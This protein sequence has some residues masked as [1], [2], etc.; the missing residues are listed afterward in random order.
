VSRDAAHLVPRLAVIAARSS[1]AY[2]PMGRSR[3]CTP[4]G[5]SPVPRRPGRGRPAGAAPQG[6][7]KPAARTWVVPR[8]HPGRD[9]R[10]Y[11]PVVAAVEEVAPGVEVVGPG[12]CALAAR[13]PSRY[14]R[15]EERA[16][17]RIVEHIARSARWRR[18]PA[19]P[20]GLR[21]PSRRPAGRLIPPGR[22]AAF[23]R[24]L[25]ISTV[26]DRPGRPAAQLGIGTP[27]LRR[28]A[29][30]GRVGTLRPGRRPAQRMPRA[31]RAATR[32]TAAAAGPG[33][34]ADLDEPSN[35][36][37]RRVRRP[38]VGRPAARAAGRVRAGLHP[39]GHRGGH[40]ARRGA[41]PDLAARRAAEC[42][43]HR[44]RCAGSWTAGCSGTNRG[45]A[46]PTGGILRL[47][48]VPEGVV[49]HAG[50]QLRL[51]GDAGHDASGRTGRSPGYRACSAP[52]R[53]SRRYPVVGTTRRTRYA[54]C[55]GATSAAR[56]ARYPGVRRFRTLP[57]RPGRCPP[58]RRFPA[59]APPRRRV[60]S[61]DTPRVRRPAH[62]AGPEAGHEDPVETRPW[63]GR[64][65]PSR[66]PSRHRSRP[67]GP[68]E[69]GRGE[70]GR[71]EQGRADEAG[72]ARAG[73]V[74]RSAG[75]TRA[76]LARPVA[77]TLHRPPCSPSR[78]PCRCTTRP[79]PPSG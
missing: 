34:D 28:P 72:R 16:A 19:S 49:A 30:G 60:R 5:Y 38:A 71:G 15:L 45:P 78:W 2:P 44:D 10:A 51:W 40:R 77:T 48:L 46:R 79:V 57:R 54:W 73:N 50:L 7:A 67:T 3:S 18:R 36:S 29:P 47:R 37:T 14:F 13:G 4:T 66:R 55:R 27:G 32:G 53:C 9:A 24:R 69:Q 56:P 70:Q 76:G 68:G 42:G 41:A 58:Y 20:T 21:R 23:P 31:G 65:R 59:P 39:A 62:P 52:R 43:G 12:A 1:K 17:E 11:E 63:S 35:S 74:G 75:R 8:P 6:G 25:D 61:R 22:T 33:R 26:T 64:S